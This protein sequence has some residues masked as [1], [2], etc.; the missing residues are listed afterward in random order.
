MMRYPV[1]LVATHDVLSSESDLR[2]I[3]VVVS[4]PDSATVHNPK[5]SLI[6]HNSYT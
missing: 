5:A 6:L 2:K 4:S 1:F 3:L